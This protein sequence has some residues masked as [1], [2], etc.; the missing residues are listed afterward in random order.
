MDGQSL[1]RSSL[2]ATQILKYYLTLDSNETMSDARTHLSCT[3]KRFGSA[4]TMIPMERRERNGEISGNCNRA[5]HRGRS[6][7]TTVKIKGEVG[8]WSVS[9]KNASTTVHSKDM[10]REC[11]RRYMIKIIKHKNVRL[12]LWFVIDL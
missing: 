1:L 7:S 4:K 8:T 10:L 11:I 6:E 2:S 3:F 9:I 12:S 5:Q